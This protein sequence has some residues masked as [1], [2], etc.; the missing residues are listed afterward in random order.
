MLGRRPGVCGINP[1]EGLVC[2]AFERDTATISANIAR[3]RHRTEFEVFIAIRNY[4]R[5]DICRGA[6]YSQIASN[7]DIIRESRIA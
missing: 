4:C 2:S 5:L 1:V 7:C 6:I 3:R